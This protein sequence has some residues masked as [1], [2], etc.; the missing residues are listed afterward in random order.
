ME[1]RKTLYKYTGEY[2]GD[3]L[4][5]PKVDSL[6]IVSNTKPLSVV[7]KPEN[8]SNI[9]VFSNNEAK[10]NVDEVELSSQNNNR[11]EEKSDNKKKWLNGKI[12]QIFLCKIDKQ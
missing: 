1:C 3:Y 6:N 2:Y 10:A 12:F 7:S 4:V 8:N 9:E 5:A 11:I